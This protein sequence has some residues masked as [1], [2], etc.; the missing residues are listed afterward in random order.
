[1]SRGRTISIHFGN[2]SATSKVRASLDLHWYG[3]N[4]GRA[5]G[6]A[7]GVGIGMFSGSA[8]FM[9]VREGRT[10]KADPPARR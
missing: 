1:M 10:G 2:H 9:I 7:V 6:T 5:A 4:G 3:R 8:L